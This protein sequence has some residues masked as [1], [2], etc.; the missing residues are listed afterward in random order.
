LTEDLKFAENT[1]SRDPDRLRRIKTTQ[2]AAL[3][4]MLWIAGVW[5]Y[6]LWMTV[7]FL[8]LWLG[9]FAPQTA[10]HDTANANDPSAIQTTATLS[11]E[12]A[13]A[14]CRNPDASGKYHIGCGVSPPTV[15]HQVELR[16]PEE[17]RAQKLRPGG[18]YITLTVDAEGNP[19][20]IHVKNSMVDKVNKIARSAQKLL[21]DNIVDA[22]RQYKFKPATFE[23]KPVPVDLNIE[24]NIDIF[25]SCPFH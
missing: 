7:P 17:A 24:M 11:T 10:K 21:E 14:P 13:R 18:A 16:Y 19:T 9:L 23:G 1:T 20:N 3:T 6:S 22:V 5:C 25:W 8:V 2:L 12:S 4:A 15:I